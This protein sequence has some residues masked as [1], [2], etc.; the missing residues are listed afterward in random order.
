MH[1]ALKE[2]HVVQVDELY[3]ANVREAIWL[4]ELPRAET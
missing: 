4:E 3:R 1:G 2:L